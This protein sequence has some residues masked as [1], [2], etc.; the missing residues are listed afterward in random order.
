MR[1]ADI[2]QASE[3]CARRT[4]IVL[5]ISIPVSTFVDN[6]FLLLILVLWLVTLPLNLKDLA[7]STRHSSVAM[8]ALGLFLLIAA[9]TLYGPSP[10]AEALSVLG[11]Y[12]D[13]FF[14]PILATFFTT[15]HSRDRALLCLA[16]AIVLSLIVSHAARA[17]LLVG[18]PVLPRYPEY[19]GGFKFS[20][21]H[22]IVMSLGA[23]LFSLLARDTV[24][25]AKRVAF[26]VLALLC[27]HNVLFVVIGRTGYV[28]L[29]TLVV[30]LVAT[31]T[32]GRKGLLHAA[33]AG[34]LV[35]S[36]AYFL[37]SNFRD[38]V[39]TAAVEFT[40]WRAGHDIADSSVGLRIEWY[41][42]SF[43]LIKE[44]PLT[45]VG[46]GGFK[47]AYAETVAGTGAIV[48]SNP[49][50]D[51]LLLTAQVGVLGLLLL[52]ITYTAL[53]RVSRELPTRLERDLARG[54]VLTMA[55][56]GMFNSLL[57]DHTEGLLFAWLAALLLGGLGTNKA[58]T[59]PV[60]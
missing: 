47:Q 41:R 37:S 50:N 17:G 3:T 52:I 54:L 36:T 13:L 21:T 15:R 38:R 51:Y 27:V 60:T 19:P 59:E 49:H 1:Y 34:V 22:S 42:T 29:A 56:G 11:K 53:W 24:K 18:N 5:G 31:N 10:R 25:L 43:E 8:S 48:P 4:A 35:L 58:S 6:V 12:A 23:F 2:A 46:T 28:V 33:L 9:G 30:Y 39:L 14:I 16:I 55:I 20:V 44:N 7:L 45:G 32:R 26:G 40:D 57:L